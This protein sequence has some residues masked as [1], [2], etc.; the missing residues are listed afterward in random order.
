MAGRRRQRSSPTSAIPNGMGRTRRGTEYVKPLRQ[1]NEDFESNAPL[2]A[3]SVPSPPL[4]TRLQRQCRAS[5]CSTPWHSL[6]DGG[7]GKAA[8]SRTCLELVAEVLASSNQGDPSYNGAVD[9]AFFLGRLSQLSAT[10]RHACAPLWPPLLEACFGREPACQLG[11]QLPHRGPYTSGSVFCA[12]VDQ[13]RAA[14]P[15][16]LNGEQ[17]SLFFRS[18]HI[19]QSNVLSAVTFD[20]DAFDSDASCVPYFRSINAA[21]RSY[22]ALWTSQYTCAARPLLQTQAPQVHRPTC[23]SLCPSFP[24]PLQLLLPRELLH[25]R[26]VDD[27]CI[28]YPAIMSSPSQ[29]SAS[30]LAA[31]IS[32]AS[33][34]VHTQT[35]SSPLGADGRRLPYVTVDQLLKSITSFVAGEPSPGASPASARAIKMHA[36]VP[37]PFYVF[38][39]DIIREEG[40]ETKFSQS[41]SREGGGGQVLRLVWMERERGPA[42][43]RPT[44]LHDLPSTPSSA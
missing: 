38:L 2:F 7:S 3:T 37:S 19:D 25:R 27:S 22:V 35:F 12:L 13:L 21:E 18:L 29:L 36:P 14:S 6:W 23:L 24:H 20:S 1:S 16:S 30:Q 17:P 33:P 42:A 9:A 43:A 4:P 32:R 10:L 26:L 40:L 41:R 28:K 34:V 44:R 5:Y 15:L 31:L 11:C 39:H 8:R